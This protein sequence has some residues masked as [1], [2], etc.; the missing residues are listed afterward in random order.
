[1][2]CQGMI[3]G[4]VELR[5]DKYSDLDKC[6]FVTFKFDAAEKELDD[7]NKLVMNEWSAP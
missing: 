5:L 1:M 3:C 4:I 6:K 2:E 7:L